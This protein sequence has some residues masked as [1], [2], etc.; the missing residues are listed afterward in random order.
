MTQEIDSHFETLH[1]ELGAPPPA[2]FGAREGEIVPGPHAMMPL[3]GP[4][5]ET[6]PATLSQAPESAE[7]PAA[8]P[9]PASAAHTAQEPAG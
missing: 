8:H 2:G 5:P 1:R 9:E 7:P 4:P 3:P 6:V